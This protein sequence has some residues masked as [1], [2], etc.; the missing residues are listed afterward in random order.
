MIRAWLAEKETKR[1]VDHL[2]KKKHGEKY[3]VFWDKITDEYNTY[4]DEDTIK[5]YPGGDAALNAWRHP[6]APIPPPAHVGAPMVQPAAPAPAVPPPDPN[7]AVLYICDADSKNELFGV[8]LVKGRQM[9]R[10]DEL[11][12]APGGDEALRCWG[13][14]IDKILRY[15]TKTQKY[16]VMLSDRTRL[17]IKKRWIHNWKGWAEAEQK[18]K[19]RV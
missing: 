9:M 10:L 5:K 11:K 3:E 8:K 16:R 6:R 19:H 1:R 15:D 17:D 14:K 2:G 7:D 4:E 12:A 13:L 18:W